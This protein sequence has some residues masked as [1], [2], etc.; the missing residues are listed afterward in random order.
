LVY[1]RFFRR[2]R[3]YV[4]P[5]IPIRILN[6]AFVVVVFLFSVMQSS[7]MG[8]SLNIPVRRH[9]CLAWVTPMVVPFFF[10]PQSR[11]CVV[12]MYRSK[13]VVWRWARGREF[14]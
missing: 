11:I 4:V 1:N 10:V 9:L 7:L 14:I 12:L 13:M 5:S 8:T 6:V 3:K 2:S